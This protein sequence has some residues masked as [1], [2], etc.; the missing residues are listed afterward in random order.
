MNHMDNIS[1]TAAGV[2]TGGEFAAHTR[3]EA[4]LNI[5]GPTL[6]PIAL[7]GEFQPWENDLL[8][9]NPYPETMPEPVLGIEFDDGPRLNVTVGDETFTFWEDDEGELFDTTLQSEDGRF[10]FS[11]DDGAEE[12][13]QF[14]DWAHSI[15]GNIS[16]NIYAATTAAINLGVQEQ[17]IKIALRK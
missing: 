15:R 9:H 1:R 12:H 17:L 14:V 7:T 3:N 16:A 8:A 11:D 10:G 2:P 13:E 5:I 6:D 4:D